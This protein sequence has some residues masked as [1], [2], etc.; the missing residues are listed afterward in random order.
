MFRVKVVNPDTGL[1]LASGDRLRLVGDGEDHKR[2][3]LLSVRVDDTLGEEVWRIDVSVNTTPV[4]VLNSHVP[5]LKS[6]LVEDP[7]IGGAILLPAVRKVLDVL[8]DDF[9]GSEWQPDWIKFVKNVHPD[10]DL[11]KA[12]NDGDREMWINDVMEL[13]AGTLTFVSKCKLVNAGFG[14]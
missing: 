6:R 8:A 13:F 2:R 14:T 1:I 4:L 7:L 11:D 12:L 10:I 9:D 5:G 3:P